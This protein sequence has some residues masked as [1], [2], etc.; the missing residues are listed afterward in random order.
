MSPLL[1]FPSTLSPHSLNSSQTI[2]LLSRKIFV[3]QDFC[4]PGYFGVILCSVPTFPS[5]SKFQTKWH[6]SLG[7]VT[8]IL[9]LLPNGE[10]P[11]VDI[12]TNWLHWQ[13]RRVAQTPHC[14]VWYFPYFSSGT[15][16]HILSSF[17]F[18]LLQ[19]REKEE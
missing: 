11:C 16:H 18:P 2:F 12:G 17:S 5:S 3:L 19:S 4:Y 15:S 10:Y 8:V 13:V 7:V 1:L 9:R 14:S 6:P